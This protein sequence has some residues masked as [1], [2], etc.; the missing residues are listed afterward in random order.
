LIE[1]RRGNF[2]RAGCD[3]ITA[4]DL[5]PDLPTPHHALGLL[6]SQ[7]GKPEE[8]ERRYRAALRVDP[9][10]APSR[11]NLGRLLF[12]RAAFEQSREQFLRLTKVAPDFQEGWTGLCESLLKLDRIAEAQGVLVAARQRLG[13]LLVHCCFSTTFVLPPQSSK[14]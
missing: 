1:L 9:G 14:C 2:E 13:A 5:N 3:F 10:F 6:A 12:E 7:E 4:R 8:A 11:I